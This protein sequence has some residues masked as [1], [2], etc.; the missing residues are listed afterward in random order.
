MNEHI[1]LYLLALMGMHN[2]DKSC[3]LMSFLQ[4]FIVPRFHSV[5]KYVLS[6]LC[7]ATA[8]FSSLH[9]IVIT[10]IYNL[11]HHSLYILSYLQFILEAVWFLKCFV[12]LL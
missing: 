4:T 8:L 6:A 2:V 10:V 1:L 3:Y 9:I 12:L 7:S 11:I 5:M